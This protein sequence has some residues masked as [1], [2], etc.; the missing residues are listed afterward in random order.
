MERFLP[1]A[2]VERRTAKAE[3]DQAKVEERRTAQKVTQLSVEAEKG[4]VSKAALK[5][6]QQVCVFLCA[7]LL[8]YQD[9]SNPGK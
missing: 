4:Q 5:R 2:R 1:V 6:G 7:V 8:S 3:W 9:C